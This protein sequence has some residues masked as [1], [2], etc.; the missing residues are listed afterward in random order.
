[1][2]WDQYDLA[3]AQFRPLAPADSDRASKLLSIR[4][5][6]AMLHLESRATEKQQRDANRARIKQRGM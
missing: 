2:T 3:E 6:Q 1:M 5:T 4:A